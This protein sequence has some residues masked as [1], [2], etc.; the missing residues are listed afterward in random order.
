V[1]PQHHAPNR[2][3]PS[4]PCPVLACRLHPDHDPHGDDHPCP[5]GFE[6]MLPLVSYLDHVGR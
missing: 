5:V 3:C 1:P 2:P 6:A 4:M